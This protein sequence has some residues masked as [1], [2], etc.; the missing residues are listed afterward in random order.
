MQHIS[1]RIQSMFYNE[2][3]PRII[4]SLKSIVKYSYLMNELNCHI[5]L[6]NGC[7]MEFDLTFHVDFTLKASS[8]III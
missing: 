3:I 4:H 5:K 1:F 7:K 2:Q 8:E 6:N